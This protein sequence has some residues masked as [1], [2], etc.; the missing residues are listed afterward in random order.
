MPPAKKRPSG[1]V[2]AP[3]LDARGELVQVGEGARGED[4]LR[5]PIEIE[6]LADLHDAAFAHQ[7]HAVAHAH[8]LLGV[9]GDDDRGRVRLVQDGERL[10]A[11]ALS[12][13]RVEA[14][15]RLVHQQHA[16]ARRDRAGKRHALLLAA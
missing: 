13:P 16:R 1:V 12:E 14:R 11:H 2:R 8:R 15:E 9:M 7:R 10:L 6:R 5:R 3:L 4:V